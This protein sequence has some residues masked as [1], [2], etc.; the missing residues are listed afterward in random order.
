MRLSKIKKLYALIEEKGRILADHI[1]FENDG[2]RDIILIKDV[3]A[4][5]TDEM[6]VFETYSEYEAYEFLESKGLLNNKK[7][8]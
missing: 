4:E 2:G 8:I 3:D 7:L 6:F 1:E 5:T